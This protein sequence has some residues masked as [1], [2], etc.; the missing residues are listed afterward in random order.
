M[1]NPVFELIIGMAAKNLR[2]SQ[3]LSV[4]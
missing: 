3:N 2:Q 1:D 4:G